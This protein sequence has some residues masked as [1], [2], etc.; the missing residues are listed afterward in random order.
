MPWHFH[1]GSHRIQQQAVCKEEYS[2]TNCL[3]GIYPSRCEQKLSLPEELYYE[4]L[5]AGESKEEHKDLSLVI[6]K[7]KPLS[8]FILSYYQPGISHCCRG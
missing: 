3:C 4:V 7:L 2:Q 8:G 6:P 1:A 5:V